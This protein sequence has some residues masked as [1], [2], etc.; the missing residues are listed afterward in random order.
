MSQHADHAEP[1]DVLVV[2]AGPCGCAA[3][4]TLARSGVRVGL[5]DRARF[6]RPKLCGGLLTFKTFLALE[7][8]AAIREPDL[9]Q[10]VTARTANYH[11]YYQDRLLRSGRASRP[12]VLVRRERFDALLLQRARDAG[13][14][15]LHGR[16]LECTPAKGEVATAE[17]GL[18]RARFLIGA[19]GVNSRMRRALRPDKVRWHAGLADAVEIRAPR[20]ALPEPLRHRQ[21]PSLHAGFNRTG[22]GWIFPNQDDLVLGMCGLREARSLHSSFFGM[23]DRFQV[24]ESLRRPLRGHPLPYGNWL[25]RPGRGALLLAGDAAGIVEP[26]LG[27]G[28]FYALISG[29]FAALSV[30]DELQGR[31]MADCAYMQRLARDIL[32][33]LRASHALRRSLLPLVNRFGQAPLDL[34]LKLGGTAL[35]QMV[36]GE[37]SYWLL[38]RKHWRWD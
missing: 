30:L 27:E 26:T 34:F 10:A 1:F 22:Y 18:L 3:A 4:L 35:A 24:P 8:I 31:A 9:E 36:H 38:R 11:L 6:P 21:E 28:I 16:A 25:P 20:E 15:Q 12:F 32:P 13:T 23:L 29:H 19:D 33:E 7:H 2:G 14:V 17:H 37:R 5:L